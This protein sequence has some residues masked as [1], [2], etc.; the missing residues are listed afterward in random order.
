M[1]ELIEQLR[2]EISRL[3]AELSDLKRQR[4]AVVAPLDH[5][6]ANIEQR[7][8]A[9]QRMLVTYG[10]TADAPSNAP[11]DR[12]P[13]RYRAPLRDRGAASGTDLTWAEVQRVD[14]PTHLSGRPLR[15]DSK[16]AKI[17]RAT[18]ALLEASGPKSRS[19]I[20]DFLIDLG[21][22]GQER[23]SKGYLSVILSYARELFATDHRGI[24]YLKDTE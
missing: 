21:I 16:R 22:M 14:I 4:S 10:G 3:T 8:R 5:D 11:T 19:E 6:I 13:R 2:R 23:D 1:L 15:P 17:I 12:S 7:L 24:W 20:A 18:R 9:A